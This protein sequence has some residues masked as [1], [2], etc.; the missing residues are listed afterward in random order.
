MEKYCCVY[1]GAKESS[2]VWL[3]NENCLSHPNGQN[4][5]KHLIKQMPHLNIGIRTDIALVFSCP[6]LREA[7][8]KRPVSGATGDNLD[9]ILQRLVKGNIIENFSERYDFRITNASD[10]VYP[11][12]DKRVRTEEL[13]TYLNAPKNL[14]RLHDELHDI[15]RCIIC[16]GKKANET[17]LKMMF[18]SKEF[19]APPINVRHL[20]PRVINKIVLE[21]PKADKKINTRHRLLIVIEDDLL[22]NPNIEALTKP[23]NK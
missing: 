1:C 10:R 9:F 7:E 19:K 13:D 20:S 18:H 12:K 15:Q 4:K 11:T 23:F 3:I 16:F 5:G 2:I 14:K 22:K 8:N 21:N 17:V 6:G